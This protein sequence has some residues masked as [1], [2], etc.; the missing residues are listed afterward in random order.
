MHLF[1]A[2]CAFMFLPFLLG[3]A[4]AK[5]VRWIRDRRV[6]RIMKG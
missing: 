1:I 4:L 6:E 3:F 5:T 2:A